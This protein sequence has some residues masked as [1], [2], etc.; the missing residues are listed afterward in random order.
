MSGEEAQ[1][2]DGKL[3]EEEWMQMKDRWSEEEL[4]AAVIAY[5]EMSH[6]ESI[7]RSFVK[8]Q[9]YK[10]LA[11][12]FGRTAKSFEYR[13]QNISYVYDQMGKPWVK[14]LKPAKNVGTRTAELI[15]R[16]ISEI[17]R[18]DVDDKVAEF[19]P[20]DLLTKPAGVRSPKQTTVPTTT[21]ERDPEV[22]KWVLSQADGRCECCGELAPFTNDK[23]CPFLEV[24]HLR[25]LADGGSDKV[26]N[27]VAVCP[28]CHR[29][30]H[31]GV[32]R[33]VMLKQ[34]YGRL[35]RLLRE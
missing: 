23:G 20:D 3:P 33:S 19:L 13:M 11:E 15:E 22:K 16:I 8:S 29:E 35:T 24:H 12:R 31:F 26:T 34:M 28:N 14:G 2:L 7:G 30:L 4:R 18:R 9:Y 10:E 21:Y 1:Q 27:A 6:K 17:E 32:N 5:R 25:T